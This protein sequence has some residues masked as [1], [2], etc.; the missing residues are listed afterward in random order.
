MVNPTLK[1]KKK[2][3]GD[4]MKMEVKRNVVEKREKGSEIEIWVGVKGRDGRVHRSSKRERERSGEPPI[5]PFPLLPFSF[6]LFFGPPPSNAITL[7][8]LSLL[9]HLYFFIKK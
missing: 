6:L 2:R 9:R 5:L 8:S 3:Y 7:L 4:G 1:I